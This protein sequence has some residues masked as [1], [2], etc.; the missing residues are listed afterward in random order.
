MTPIL[1]KIIEGTFA[2]HISKDTVPDF[3]TAKIDLFKI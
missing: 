1:Y 2:L 3:A